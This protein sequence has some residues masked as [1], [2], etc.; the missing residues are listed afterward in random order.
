M[1]NKKPTFFTSNYSLKELQK[2]L[3]SNTNDWISV[4]RIIERVRAL[5]ENNEIEIKDKNYRY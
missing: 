4:K 2:K 5:V 3:S 1:Q